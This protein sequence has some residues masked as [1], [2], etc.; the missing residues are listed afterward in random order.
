MGKGKKSSGKHYTSKGQR[1]SVSQRTLNAMRRDRS[2]AEKMINI[3][4]AWLQ[5]RNPWITIENPNKEQ[6][7]RRFIRVRVADLNGDPKERAK[8]MFVMN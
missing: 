7:N 4:R 1:K 3:Q 6:T 5:G 8:K 2:C